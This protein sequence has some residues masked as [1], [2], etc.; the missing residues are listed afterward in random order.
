MKKLDEQTQAYE[1][2]KFENDL[3]TSQ[4]QQQKQQQPSTFNPNKRRDPNETSTTNNRGK[5][6]VSD[7]ANDY[8][9]TNTNSSEKRL[10]QAEFDATQ[11]KYTKL[12]I[13]LNRG[14]HDTS[15]LKGKINEYK[16]KYRLLGVNVGADE[17]TAVEQQQQPQQR[18]ESKMD[19]Y[20][21][22]YSTTKDSDG[23]ASNK[24]EQARIK[25]IFNLLRED[26][27]GDK[28]I[29]L[30]N[31]DIQ[32]LLKRVARQQTS[33]DGPKH[34]KSDKSDTRSKPPL[35][36][37]ASPAKP[38]AAERP[39]WGYKN[40]EG[41]K[42]VPN[43]KK[44]PFVAEKQMQARERQKNQLD[45]LKKTVEANN[46]K[47]TQQTTAKDMD[48]NIEYADG[49]NKANDRTTK[50]NKN[51]AQEET[52]FNL[53][54]NLKQNQQQVGNEDVDEDDQ[55]THFAAST[56]TQRRLRQSNDTFK[57]GFVPFTRTDEVLNPAH[58]TSPCPPSRE[59]TATKF[60]RDKARKVR[61]FNHLVFFLLFYCCH[62]VRLVVVRIQKA[63]EQSMRPGDYGQN[64]Y[65]NDGGRVLK[66]KV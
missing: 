39:K 55:S 49:N 16:A 60:N 14:G 3:K 29:D 66:S 21:S 26:T 43:S 63:F 12:L 59:S 45:Y 32:M 33:S 10:L 46:R 37:Q 4:I 9:T 5:E 41:K 50:S 44:D 22:Q 20:R 47:Q 6:N 15:K 18:I 58:A 13:K 23:Q 42:A 30:T 53:L 17:T 25:Q 24:Q 62:I 7:Y 38:K 40:L 51:K 2:L 54:N 31:E 61:L 65:D 34:E 36:Q 8:G 11:E 28:P 35:K 48:L 64:N 57:S 19:S 56:N 52:I 1:N 27:D